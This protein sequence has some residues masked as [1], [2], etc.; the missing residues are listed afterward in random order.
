MG[1][2]SGHTAVRVS[3]AA[4]PPREDSSVWRTDLRVLLSGTT[5]PPMVFQ[6]NI[7]D[8]YNLYLTMTFVQV[9]SSQWRS[10]V[11]SITRVLRDQLLPMTPETRVCVISSCALMVSRWSPLV[12]H[13]RAPA[14]EEREHTGAEKVNHHD[15]KTILISECLR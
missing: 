4:G 13:W 12:P 14:V 7:N 9:T 2:P 1:R 11:S 8:Q 10:S 15:H 5:T 3:W 6:V